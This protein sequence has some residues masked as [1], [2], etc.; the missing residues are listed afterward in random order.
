MLS[1]PPSTVHQL[2][3][4]ELTVRTGPFGI[5]ELVMPGRQDVRECKL[6]RQSEVIAVFVQASTQDWDIDR[7]EDGFVSHAYPNQLSG[8]VLVI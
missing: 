4:A 7:H 5:C 1:L 8:I 3:A 6:L 2:G